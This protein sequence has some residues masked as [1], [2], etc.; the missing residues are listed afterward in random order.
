MTSRPVHRLAIALAMSLPLAATAQDFDGVYEYGFCD[1]PPFVAL[2]I[3]GSEV[4]YYETP[5]TL[6]DAAPQDEPAGAIRYTM[7]CDHGSGPQPQTVLFFRD[8][9]G[10]LVLRSDGLEDRFVSCPVD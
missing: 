2:T 10:A 7:S 8:A 1:D 9:E 5:C 4:S 3:A 6:S